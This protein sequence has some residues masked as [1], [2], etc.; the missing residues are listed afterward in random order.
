MKLKTISQPFLF[1]GLAL[2]LIV[3]AAQCQDSRDAP[4]QQLVGRPLNILVLGDSISWGQGLRP[5]NK[6]WHHL[7]IWLAQHTGRRV[8]E[9]V[10]AH[11]GAVIEAESISKLSPDNEVNVAA[12]TLIEQLQRALRHYGDA[13]QVDLVLVSG[14]VNDVGA[15]FVLNAANTTT[16]IRTLTEAKCGPPMESLLRRITS[17]FP[18]AYVIVTSYYPFVSDKTRNDMFMRALTKKFYK[19][20]AGD[21]KLSQEAIFRR[22]VANSDQWYR[23][24]TKS[25]EQA[26]NIVNAE[27]GST[28]SQGRVRFAEVRLLPE[29]SFRT[30]ETQLWDFERSP[31]RRLLVIL[32]FGK[33]LLRTN[34]DVRRQRTA[35]CKEYWKA[36]LS[37][38]SS[39]KKERKNEELL[40]RYASL[41]HPNRQGAVSYT[42]AITE[43]LKTVFPVVASK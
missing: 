37:E 35:S 20:V 38:T 12:P 41:G 23:S 22:M 9:K 26:V 11:S 5:E 21:A 7:K 33:I 18:H 32:S 17:S 10:E 28:Q 27:L 16:D 40:C 43:H 29:H 42:E 14:C 2:C 1:A 8:I 19:A 34:D 30:P 3:P 6:S 39:Q 4:V 25:L 36:P 13:T 15:R 24:S 31:L